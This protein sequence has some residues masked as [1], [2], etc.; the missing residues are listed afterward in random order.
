M[1]KKQG[2]KLIIACGSLK[3]DLQ[4]FGNQDPSV[5]LHFMPQNLHRYPD[6]MREELQQAID[7]YDREEPDKIIVLGYGLCSNGVAGLLAG[8]NGLYIPRVHDC[9]SLYLGGVERYHAHF[10]S[11]PGTYY[12]T[13]SWIENAKDPLGLMEN[14]YKE[15]VGAELA[16]ETIEWELKN[17][18]YICYIDPGTENSVFYRDRAK[19]NAKV[20]GKK[21]LEIKGS[22]DFFRKI[23]YGPYNSKDF[24]FV[25]P[26]QTSNYKNFFKQE[27]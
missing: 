18:E 7:Y 10:S 16:K 2:N 21:Y 9:I 4:G 1:R 23:V 14:E 20:L 27:K 26:N 6:K 11:R 13:R 8:R 22:D 3:A 25:E 15:R 19:E 17:Y 5:H 12:L 24:V